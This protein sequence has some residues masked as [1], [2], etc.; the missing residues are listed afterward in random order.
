MKQQKNFLIFFFSKLDSLPLIAITNMC[1]FITHHSYAG[2]FGRLT[3]SSET[4]L[5]NNLLASNPSLLLLV[6]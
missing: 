2:C 1:E 5:L 4:S 6:Q 3:D